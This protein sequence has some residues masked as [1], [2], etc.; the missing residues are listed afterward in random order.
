VLKQKIKSEVLEIN[1]K[2]SKLTNLEKSAQAQENVLDD[3]IAD[4]QTEKNK[5]ALLKQKENFMKKQ[6][7]AILDSLKVIEKKF[8]KMLDQ[9]KTLTQA[10]KID[11]GRQLLPNNWTR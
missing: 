11:A 1:I 4:F 5:I 2:T 7:D 8:P 6:I 10:Y 9:Y 3:K